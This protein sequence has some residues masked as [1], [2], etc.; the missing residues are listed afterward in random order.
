MA[1]SD[2]PRFDEPG[3]NPTRRRTLSWP[4]R[5]G[6]STDVVL[7]TLLLT[8]LAVIWAGGLRG[9]GSEFDE[10]IAVSFPDRILHGAVPYRDFETFYDPGYSYVT[11]AVFKVFGSSL[12]SERAVGLAV[13]VLSVLA[14]FILV[15]RF[16]RMA[17]FGAGLVGAALLAREVFAGAEK[18]ALTSRSRSSW[19]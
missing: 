4:T 5:F 10:G 15:S 1:R 9:P 13:A 3:A 11:A 6:R 7:A 12:Y 17:A 14:L 18:E 16:S 2:V 19:A 8:G